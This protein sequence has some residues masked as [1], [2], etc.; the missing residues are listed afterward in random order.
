MTHVKRILMI[1]SIILLAIMA[2][3]VSATD[4]CVENEAVVNRLLHD[5]IE[6]GD[7]TA[8]TALLTADFTAHDPL[9]GEM[10]RDTFI[11]FYADLDIIVPEYALMSGRDMVALQIL[12]I[13]DPPVMFDTNRFDF[14]PYG[15]A[16]TLW[17]F[18]RVENGQISAA[19]LIYDELSL[20]QFVGEPSRPSDGNSRGFS[21]MAG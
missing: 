2:L 1:L 21:G 10:D 20:L 17:T 19:W 7:T 3:P 11:S 16:S 18:F 13:Q 15:V 14:G 12:N 4:T 9:N 5:F 8:A 6:H